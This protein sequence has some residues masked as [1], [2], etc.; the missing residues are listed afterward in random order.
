V[1]D[2]VALTF[3]TLAMTGTAPSANTAY[4]N[5]TGTW[6]RFRY[7]ASLGGFVITPAWNAPMFFFRVV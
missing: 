7:I 1:F 5:T 3:N 6:N 4:G 2:P